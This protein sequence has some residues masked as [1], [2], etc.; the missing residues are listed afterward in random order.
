[1]VVGSLEISLRMEGIRS[2]KEKRKPRQML[3][4]RLRTRF[5]LAASEVDDQDTLNVL[6]LGLATVG[7]H[8]GPVEQVLRDA[9]EWIVSMGIGEVTL[10]QLEIERY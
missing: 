8:R 9:A 4:S 6:T 5:R 3:I 2:L 1:M 7:P 10:E